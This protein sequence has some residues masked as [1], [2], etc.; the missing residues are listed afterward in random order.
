[1]TET[2]NTQLKEVEPIEG[3]PFTAVKIEEKWFLSF[4]QYRLSE[5]LESKEE[6][7]DNS[8]DTSWERL[9]TIM[10]I[11]IENCDKTQETERRLKRLEE[12]VATRY[13]KPEITKEEII[14]KLIKE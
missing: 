13:E 8:K 7:I 14:E 1:M 9:M 2:K 6:C 10:N 11:V 4:G 3:T 12:I 5:M